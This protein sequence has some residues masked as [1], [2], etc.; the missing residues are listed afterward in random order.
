MTDKI[1]PAT[2]EE[3]AHERNW[4]QAFDENDDA[5]H[6][7]NV[8]VF[9]RILARLDAAEAELEAMFKSGQTDRE[10]AEAVAEISM[11]QV[12]DQHDRSEYTDSAW[13]RVRSELSQ[14]YIPHVAAHV[15]AQVKP[16][17]E[18]VGRAVDTRID[19]RWLSDARALLAASERKGGE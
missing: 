9:I 3:I 17:R 16:W 14:Q 19:D 13:S 6:L 8:G 5:N 1:T 18:I 4:V 7:I 15:A 12:F 11:T 2:D 10:C